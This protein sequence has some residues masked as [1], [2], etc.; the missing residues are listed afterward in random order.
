MTSSAS[1]IA[2]SVLISILIILIIGYL[3]NRFYLKKDLNLLRKNIDELYVKLNRVSSDDIEF[4]SG[5]VKKEKDVVKG[6]KPYDSMESIS[7]EEQKRK[8]VHQSILKK[9]A[10]DMIR[11][12]VLPWPIQSMSNTIPAM[13]KIAERPLWDD[14]VRN[15]I[16]GIDN[17]FGEEFEKYQKFI[18]EYASVLP[19]LA[20]EIQRY[21]MI[22]PSGIITEFESNPKDNPKE[23]LYKSEL[24]FSLVNFK[25]GF[26][27]RPEVKSEVKQKKLSRAGSLITLSFDGNSVAI[28]PQPLWLEFNTRINDILESHDLHVNLQDEI[29]KAIAL[30]DEISSLKEKCTES[31]TA[32]INSDTLYGKCH[33]I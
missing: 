12:L 4:T 31:L 24:I 16:T 18:M 20:R 5:R 11:S 13:P 32:L 30:K 6:V 3:F 23:I 1:V 25:L 9:V 28:I 17:L 10:E 19:V 27:H 22:N 33:L 14:L 29:E 21:L 8:A 2:A 15:H 7:E 26:I